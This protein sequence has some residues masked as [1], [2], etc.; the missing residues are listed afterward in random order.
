MWVR[1]P[2]GPPLALERVQVVDLSP[3]GRESDEESHS[4]PS[5]YFTLCEQL[6]AMARDALC[7]DLFGTLCTKTAVREAFSDTVSAATTPD[8]YEVDAL[9]EDWQDRRS[10]YTTRTAAMGASYSYRMIAERSL[11]ATLERHEV[12]LDKDDRERILDAHE[13]L[14]TYPGV[15]TALTELSAEFELAALSN[16]DP[17][18]LRTIVANAGID[19]HLDR[20]ISA[21]DSGVFK[22]A[23]AA[24]RHAA[25]VLDR[26]VGTCWLVSAHAWDARGGAQ[27]GMLGAW[28]N[29][30]GIPDDRIGRP[31]AAVVA[32]LEA[33]PDA[34]SE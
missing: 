21:G 28:V 24:Y 11:E 20:V 25:A 31:P 7:F 32:S 29:R 2:L 19:R 33:L 27:A 8:D 4:G 26:P 12:E 17:G 3:P 16:G 5:M 1:S 22:P 6:H 30:D 13:Q 18:L 34:L 10:A 15:D 23:P 9:Y 14:D